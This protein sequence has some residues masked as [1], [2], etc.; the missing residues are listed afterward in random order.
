[1]RTKPEKDDKDGFSHVADDLQ[2][3]ALCVHGG[4][5]PEITRRIRPKPKRRPAI[6]PLGWT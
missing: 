1:M 4:I 2:Y 3:L 6:S 5:V